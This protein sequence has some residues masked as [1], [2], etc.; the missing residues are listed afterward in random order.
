MTGNILYTET[1]IHRNR[2]TCDLEVLSYIHCNNSILLHKWLL[3]M[4]KMY[5]INMM[6]SMSYNSATRVLLMD[7]WDYPIVVARKFHERFK[8][9][10][11]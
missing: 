8:R 7:G 1:T 11:K 6:R 3:L 5:I 10:G 2:Q 4:H 9:I